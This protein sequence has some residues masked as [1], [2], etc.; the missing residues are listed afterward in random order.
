MT[1]LEI[2]KTNMG[3]F[4]TRCVQDIYAR[5][6]AC[7][8]IALSSIPADA[9][10]FDD[11]DCFSPFVYGIE[12]LNSLPA[13]KLGIAEEA[14]L[15]VFPMKMRLL[16]WLSMVSKNGFAFRSRTQAWKYLVPEWV[17]CLAR[18]NLVFRRNQ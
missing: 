17:S 7:K 16:T 12:S 10:E 14:S 8:R 6:L 2:E 18:D 4:W 9:V 3:E 13:Q 11:V 15:R 1:K 5:T